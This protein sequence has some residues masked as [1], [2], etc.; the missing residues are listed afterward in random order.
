MEPSAE[1]ET[2]DNL[3]PATGVGTDPQIPRGRTVLS[4]DEAMRRIGHAKALKQQGGADQLPT[5]ELSPHP[6]HCQGD[7]APHRGLSPKFPVREWSVGLGGDAEPD[8]LPHD[9]ADPCP[10]GKGQEPS[11]THAVAGLGRHPRHFVP[12]RGARDRGADRPHGNCREGVL[13]VDGL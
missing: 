4:S 12:R 13:V 1:R 11:E 5:F 2:E 6:S 10:C 7:R 3:R 8:D 9:E